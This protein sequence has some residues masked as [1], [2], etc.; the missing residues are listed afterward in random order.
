MYYNMGMFY[1]TTSPCFIGSVLICSFR[2][3]LLSLFM[4]DVFL[5]SS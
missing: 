3:F 2:S 1:C 4:I 5:L